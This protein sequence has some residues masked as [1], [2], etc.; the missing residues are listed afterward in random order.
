MVV[1][2]ATRRIICLSP[3]EVTEEQWRAWQQIQE[4]V[5][6]YS[7]PYFRPEF[8]QAV[9]K[10]RSNVEIGII[11]EKNEPVGFFPFER[12]RFQIGKPVGGRL[13]DIHAAIVAPEITW[14][15]RELLSGCKLKAWDFQ[16][17]PI[18]QT[19]FAGTH[20][21]EM[22]SSV[23]DLSKGYA[24]YESECKKN[25]G[26]EFKQL[27]RKSRKIEREIGPLKLEWQS[28][29]RAW[30]HRMME[31]KS[32]QYHRTKKTNLFSFN[33]IRQ[34]LENILSHRDRPFAGMLSTLTAGDNI[35]AVHFGMSSHGV[36]HYW[37][38][39]YD[40][41]FEKYSP[42]LILLLKMAQAAE[43]NGLKR[44]DLGEGQEQY[45]RNFRTG[46]TLVT[47][48]GV[49]VNGL[50]SLLRNSM[51]QTRNW[52][53]SSPLGAPARFSARMIRP[54]RDWLS[55]R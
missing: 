33:W 22:E 34:L 9:A 32:Q 8:T 6:L 3:N 45:K 42:G 16:F 20:P 50:T 37:F 36:L 19:E 31:W 7:S 18:T 21:V 47:S 5:P 23:I 38:P 28:A 4:T 51:R 40:V 27:L 12:H 14:S 39:A 52:M 17:L 53:K 25:H 29:D 11:E 46:Y 15:A 13:S 41:R 10:V 49:E 44:I 35:V 54:V 26:K 55:F 48:G 1:Q 24:H 2:A 43:K 30:L